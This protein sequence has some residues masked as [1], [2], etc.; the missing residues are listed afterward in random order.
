M[1]ASRPGPA[2]RLRDVLTGLSGG[3]AGV[4][5]I[6]MMMVTVIDV[7]GRYA[8]NAPLPGAFEMTQF[9]MA[10][11]VYA[12]LPR[13]SAREGHIT[14]DLLDGVTPPSVRP[15]RDL[16]INAVCVAAF[17]V[18]AWRLWILA[19][20]AAE[21]GDTTQYLRWPLA[22]IIWFGAALSA[23]TAAVHLGKVF[24]ALRGM[25]GGKAGE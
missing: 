5:L 25:A 19:G 10:A 6:A 15:L 11:I 14:I 1:A 9:L 7:A 24:A 23:A 21:W 4:L 18:L 3:A 17:A 22:P 13:V 12:G 8:L 16:A 2:A 20:E